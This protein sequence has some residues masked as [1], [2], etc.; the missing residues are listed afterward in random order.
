MYWAVVVPAA[1]SPITTYS[2]T[3]GC[4]P[5]PRTTEFR[6]RSP[7]EQVGRPGDAVAEATFRVGPGVQFPSIEARA[8]AMRSFAV[9]RSMPKGAAS[10]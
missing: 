6:P 7:F 9:W 1:P 10:R 2:V 4:S 5:R 8:S 3:A